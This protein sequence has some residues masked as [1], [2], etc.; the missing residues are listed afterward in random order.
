MRWRR[1]AKA[2]LAV[3]FGLAGTRPAY[4][5]EPAKAAADWAKA[6]VVNILMTNFAIA[7]ARLVLHRG[8]PYRLHFVND[9]SG[10]QNFTSKYVFQ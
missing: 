2:A 10:G 4:A 9:G 6:Q 3:A 5:A 8:T 1:S 7:P